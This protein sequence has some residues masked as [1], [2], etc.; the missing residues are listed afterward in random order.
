MSTA[1]W[2]AWAAWAATFLVDSTIV[3]GLAWAASVFLRARPR[4]EEFLWRAALFIALV[5]PTV[6]LG[7]GAATPH[8]RVFREPAVQSVESEKSSLAGAARGDQAADAALS[9]T[10]MARARGD[11]PAA[12]R[13]DAAPNSRRGGLDLLVSSS[14]LHGATWFWLIGALFALAL[15]LIGHRRFLRSIAR[16]VRADDIAHAHG[17]I[18]ARFRVSRPPSLTRSG[19]LRTPVTISR[20]EICV[21]GGFESLSAGEQRALLAH[22]MAHVERAD[23]EWRR[24]IEIVCALL[25]FQPLLRTGRRRLNHLAEVLADRRALE[26]TGEPAALASALR[27]VARW[28]RMTPGAAAVSALDRESDLIRRVRLILSELPIELRGPTRATRCVTMGIGTVA[29]V[30]T[31]PAVVP[32]G[33]EPNPQLPRIVEHPG[34]HDLVLPVWRTGERLLRIDASAGEAGVFGRIAGAVRAPGNRVVVLDET[35][36][37]LRIF[38]E[39]G[40]P[41]ATVPAR[42]RPPEEFIAPM[43]LQLREDGTIQ[44]EDQLTRMRFDPDGQLLERHTIDW[45]PVREIGEYYLECPGSPHFLDDD[46]IAC[47]SAII[48]DSTVAAGERRATMFFRIPPDLAFI[49]TLGTFPTGPRMFSGGSA[50]YALSGRSATFAGAPA[51]MYASDPDDYEIDVRDMTGRQLLVIRRENGRRAGT[52]FGPDLRYDE[53]LRLVAAG[54]GWAPSGIRVELGDPETAEMATDSAS[55]VG[56]LAVDVMGRIW[57]SVMETGGGNDVLHDVFDAEGR[58]VARARV[59]SEFRLLWIGEHEMIVERSARRERVVEVYRIVT[60]R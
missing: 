25:F 47:R 19:A 45:R 33:T 30:A 16:R 31:I 52:P 50:W 26:A 59:P 36:K 18:A 49:D 43:G 28:I 57:A 14:V 6:R 35:S 34:P 1:A 22:E 53:M 32:V 2:A 17:D 37:E 27:E 44:V 55:I 48:E 5:A 42:G 29:L 54:G 12:V 3:L 4:Y 10:E 46:V 13:G 7:L 60:G 9:G 24:A 21:P 41:I 40:V 23:A 51:R 20:R 38:D 39:R 8:L 11:T 56:G 15:S 58:Y